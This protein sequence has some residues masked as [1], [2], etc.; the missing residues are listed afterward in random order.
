MASAE[1]I[2]AKAGG[3]ADNADAARQKAADTQNDAR[4]AIDALDTRLTELAAQI[5]AKL[6][7]V[8]AAAAVEPETVPEPAPTEEPTPKA[9]PEPAV[10]TAEPKDA[11]PEATEPD[12]VDEPE[13]TPDEGAK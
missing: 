7:D 4:E 5:K 10:E 13:E 11:T 8:K 3:A 9:T 1:E 6:A 12:P 2:R